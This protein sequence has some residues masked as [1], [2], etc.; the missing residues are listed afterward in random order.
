M[1]S[2]PDLQREDPCD[3]EVEIFIYDAL[4]AKADCHAHIYH[5]VQ[6]AF[7]GIAP[8]QIGRCANTLLARMKMGAGALC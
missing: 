1:S 2:A 4:Q 7:P 5:Q 3:Q 6:M 8:E